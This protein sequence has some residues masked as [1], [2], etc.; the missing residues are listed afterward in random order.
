LS[1]L[2]RVLAPGRGRYFLT[3][4]SEVQAA[5]GLS[6]LSKTPGS[7]SQLR[8]L[9][10]SPHPSQNCA[11]LSRTGSHITPS[12]LHC[13]KGLLGNGLFVGACT[14]PHDVL[15]QRGLVGTAGA[16]LRQLVKCRA[17][18]ANSGASLPVAFLFDKLTRRGRTRRWWW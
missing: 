10:S 1:T 6:A 13:P 4:V 15:R 12:S 16:S 18:A 2:S 14:R 8:Q 5:C 7:V 11:A 17:Q 9:A 3:C